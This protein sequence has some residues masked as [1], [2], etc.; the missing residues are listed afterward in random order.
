ME[1]CLALRLLSLKK[2][3]ISDSRSNPNDLEISMNPFDL[4]QPMSKQ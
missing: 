1:E 2:N 3:E 4:H